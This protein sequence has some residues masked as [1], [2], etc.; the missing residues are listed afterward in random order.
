MGSGRPEIDAI[1]DALPDHAEIDFLVVQVR[2]PAP[3][4]QDEHQLEA[5]IATIRRVKER[6][7]KPIV[8]VAQ[9]SSPALDGPATM[10]LDVRL[11]PFGIPSLLSNQCMAAV[12]AKVG[13]TTD[14]GN[15]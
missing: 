10:A 15:L 3:D 12:T 13:G 4:V 14:S 11:R 9:S 2:M 8:V 7:T 6:T 5:Q 1:V